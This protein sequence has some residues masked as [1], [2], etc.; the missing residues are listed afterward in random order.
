M[1]NIFSHPEKSIAAKLIIATGLLIVIV[2][3]SFWYATLKKQEKD[4]MSI[5]TTYGE[6]F[7]KFTKRS[8]HHSMLTSNPEETQRVLENLGTPEGVQGVRIYN[9]QGNVIFSS[10][11][12]KCRLGC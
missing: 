3:F 6:S 12:K 7:V 2:S 9:H 1:K 10:D 4:V 11:I 8:T 5:A